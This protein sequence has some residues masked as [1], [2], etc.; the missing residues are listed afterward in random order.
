M[1]GRIPKLS[2]SDYQIIELPRFPSD[3]DEDFV[4]MFLCDGRNPRSVL[5]DVGLFIYE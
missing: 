4:K 1:Q 2:I 5:L 3:A